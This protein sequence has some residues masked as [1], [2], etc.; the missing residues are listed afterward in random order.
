[1]LAPG[2][3]DVESLVLATGPAEAAGV[4]EGPRRLS[5]SQVRIS[6]RNSLSSIVSCVIVVAL[7]GRIVRC[8]A[9]RS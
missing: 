4:G 9:P 2:P 8:R 6:S 5:S 3:T 7:P 1:M